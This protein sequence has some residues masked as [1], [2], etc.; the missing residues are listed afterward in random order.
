MFSKFSFA[1]TLAN[2]CMHMQGA[3]YTNSPFCCAYPVLFMWRGGL[4]KAT[5]HV[6]ESGQQNPLFNVIRVPAPRAP[7]VGEGR[8]VESKPVEAYVE[9][10]HR[11][12]E[13]DDVIADVFCGSGTIAE[14]AVLTH[15]RVVVADID[16]S[17]VRATVKRAAETQDKV[18]AGEATVQL[19][20]PK[21]SSATTP[22]QKESSSKRK[23]VILIAF[24]L[25]FLFC[26]LS[27]V[28]V[29]S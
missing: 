6:A 7:R 5:R 12:S 2:T 16:K 24:F 19:R 1:F 22:A 20:G 14:A 11:D 26:F 9:F 10:I 3:H 21:A 4:A 28:C 17:C 29:L 25:R 8:R 13:P 27:S 15:R 23:Q 18:R